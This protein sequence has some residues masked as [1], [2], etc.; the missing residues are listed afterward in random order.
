MAELRNKP[1]HFSRIDDGS[2]QANMQL[3]ISSMG[4]LHMKKFIKELEMYQYN[5]DM[6]I[7]GVDWDLS[8]HDGHCEDLFFFVCLKSPHHTPIL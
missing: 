7:C 6:V 4:Q 5:I 2:A 1:F 3:S 8:C